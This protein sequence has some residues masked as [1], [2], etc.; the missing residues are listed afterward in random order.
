[1]GAAVPLESGGPGLL[2]PPGRLILYRLVGFLPAELTKQTARRLRTR[3]Q[4]LDA[5]YEVFARDGYH[6]ATLDDIALRANSSKGALYYNFDSKEDLFAALL[7]ER[8]RA[9]ARDILGDDAV[10]RPPRVTPERWASHAVETAGSDREWNLLFWE[11]ACFAARRPEQ[12]RRLAGELRSFRAGAGAWL[13]PVLA[14]AGIESPVPTERVATIIAALANGLG[15]ELM[16]ASGE[17]DEAKAL[18]TMATGLAL[19]WRGLASAAESREGNHCAPKREG[20][21]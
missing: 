11:F 20:G 7:E 5:A 15:L 12:R 16:L 17:D 9:R 14:E 13:E 4:L 10:A 21:K 6:A 8:L 19:L 1:V 18:A 2:A 3:E